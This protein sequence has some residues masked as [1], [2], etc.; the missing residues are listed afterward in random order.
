MQCEG[1]TLFSAQDG[2]L[3]SQLH[4]ISQTEISDSCLNSRVA[5]NA[6]FYY[7]KALIAGCLCLVSDGGV[8]T[9]PHLT[10]PIGPID[11]TSLQTIIDTL[12]P[13]FKKRG[14]PFR[15]MY[16]DEHC[17]PLFENVSGY[18]IRLSYDPDYSDYVYDANELRLLAGKALHSKRN[19]FN[20]FSRTYPGYEYRPISVDDR[21][22]ALK[23]VKSWC[24]EKG[25]DCCNLCVSDYRAIRQLFDDFDILDIRGGSIRIDGRLVA[26][27]LGTLCESSDTAVINFEKAVTGYE[28]LYAAINKLVLDNAFPKVRFV[29]R[30]EDMGIMGLRKAKESYGPVRMIR[31]YEAWLQKASE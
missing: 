24:D 27:A 29:N 16:I 9:S 31:K 7:Q 30:E 26:F 14:W 21:D 3:F 10:W 4:Q 22:E 11:S 6:G 25:V 5:W 8:F 18:R 17:L 13:V 23:L 28:G 19:H 1:C 2:P 15:I 12:W 20:R